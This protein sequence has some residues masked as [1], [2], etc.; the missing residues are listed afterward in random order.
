MTIRMIEITANQGFRA[1]DSNLSRRQVVCHC[2]PVVW[3][4]LKHRSASV[5]YEAYRE[6]LHQAAER[7]PS[8]VKV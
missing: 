2:T 5:A 6:M 3:R 1:N 4:V 8:G 7:L